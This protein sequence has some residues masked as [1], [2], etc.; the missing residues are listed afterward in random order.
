MAK[1]EFCR[2]LGSGWVDLA[3]AVGV[4]VY[5]RDRFI[6]GDEARAVWEWLE[7][8]GRLGDLPD[9]LDQIDRGDL[10]GLLRPR[11]HAEPEPRRHERT[12]TAL[13]GNK[14]LPLQTRDLVT[15]EF[16]PAMDRVITDGG[17]LAVVADAGMGKSVLLGQL[18]DATADREDLGVVLLSCGAL[19]G[20]RIR[21]SLD[22]DASGGGVA[23]ARP[24]LIATLIAQKQ[25]YGRA[26]LLIDTVDL[27][28]D[29]TTVPVLAEFLRT[30]VDAGIATVFTCRLF[31]YETLLEPVHEKAPLLGDLVDARRLKPLHSGEVRHFA[32][33]FLRN[34]PNVDDPAAFVDRLL[35]LRD[36]RRAVLEICG[37]PLLL[38]LVCALFA[39]DGEPPQDLTVSR[40][41]RT[42]WENKIRV[43]RARPVTEPGAPATR[44]RVA[45]AAGRYLIDASTAAFVEEFGEIDVAEDPTQHAALEGLRSS[46]VIVAGA[47]DGRLRFFHQTCAEFVMA[48]HLLREPAARQQFIAALRAAGAGSHLWPVMIQLLYAAGRDGTGSDFTGLIDQLD[49]DVLH[50]WRVALVAVTA[51]TDADA[52]DRLAATAVSRSPEHQ[53]VLIDT[54]AAADEAL[55]RRALT[56]LGDLMPVADPGVLQRA[57]T[58][59]RTLL[60]RVPAAERA[61]ILKRMLAVAAAAESRLGNAERAHNISRNMLAGLRPDDMD[62]AHL[63]VLTDAYTAAGHLRRIEIIRLVAP[64]GPRASARLLQ[65]AVRRTMPAPARE[66][67]ID[68]VVGVITDSDA[69]RVMGWTGWQDLLT[70]VYL[71]QWDDI[72]IAAVV[73]LVGADRKIPSVHPS[74][75]ELLPF[76][77]DTDTQVRQR[78]IHVCGRLAEDDPTAVAETLVVLPPPTDRVM[79]QAVRA[80]AKRMPPLPERTAHRLVTWILAA[81]ETPDQP[82]RENADRKPPEEALQGAAHA[83]K[84]HSW[85]LQEVLKHIGTVPAGKPRERV[86]AAI[87]DGCPIRDLPVLH[88][89]IVAALSSQGA[90]DLRAR[91]AGLL[92]PVNETARQAATRFMLGPDPV[93]A[94]AA[95]RR[96]VEAAQAWNWYDSGYIAPLLAS[97]TDGVVES[98][99]QLVT[100]A[101]RRGQA[102]DEQIRSA[103]LAALEVTTAGPVCGMLIDILR[104]DPQGGPDP[105]LTLLRHA[106]EVLATRATADTATAAAYQDLLAVHVRGALA[107]LGDALFHPRPPREW[108]DRAL[109]LL[110]VL[111]LD[112]VRRTEEDVR[113][114]A[115][116]LDK[117]YPGALD[118]LLADIGAYSASIQLGLAMAAERKMGPSSSSFRRIATRTDVEPAVRTYVVARLS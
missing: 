32:T 37:N 56:I 36:Q 89:D 117:N 24:S 73:A 12:R 62:D 25:A 57:S 35:H 11:T 4:G 40:L 10:S 105:D 103:V 81:P 92:V 53:A 50:A 102:A 113:N 70:R 17:I 84:S 23:C 38:A 48:R 82:S 30:V 22:L 98:A 13:D 14:V 39:P 27:L 19:A 115:V 106:V 47:G 51:G 65:V 7:R 112:K 78:A 93:H 109:N 80:H 59:V 95:A 26:V 107:L 67:L 8:R 20:S 71:R 1:L 31:E 94:R 52:L 104:Y 42:Y 5:E 44:E 55:T 83:A 72:Q 75:A 46:G 77:W 114:I 99:L 34:A 45:L 118:S 21:S 64:A 79:T 68:M 58:A 33:E 116:V 66:T 87:V 111:P 86:I 76:S 15:T 60:P 63:E 88:D 110:R 6:R 90:L 101:R 29:P 74:V 69:R 9:A 18:Y 2:R 41:Y 61:P 91:V 28:L 54:L 85:L 3:D 96:M 43:D 100:A 16:I 97:R 108:H 49:L